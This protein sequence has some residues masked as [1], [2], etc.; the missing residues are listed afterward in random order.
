LLSSF[1]IIFDALEDFVSEVRECNVVSLRD[2][3]T[4]FEMDEFIDLVRGSN[5]DGLPDVGIE[6]DKSLDL[7]RGNIFDGLPDAGI[8]VDKLLGRGS[9]FSPDVVV[10]FLFLCDVLENDSRDKTSCLVF[11]L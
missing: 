1:D 2:V 11:F 6:V 4:E 3:D 5:F 8:G 7:S 10:E 9:I